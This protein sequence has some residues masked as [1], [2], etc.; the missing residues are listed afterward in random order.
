MEK[1][2]GFIQ[3]FVSGVISV[4]ACSDGRG[5]ALSSCQSENRDGS[6]P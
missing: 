4:T 2:D 3:L 6:L 5:V 1:Y